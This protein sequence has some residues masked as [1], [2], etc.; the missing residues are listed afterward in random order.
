MAGEVE[1]KKKKVE[2]NLVEAYNNPVRIS[3]KAVELELEKLHNQ[4][5]VGSAEQQQVIAALSL[6]VQLAMLDALDDILQS[7]SGVPVDRESTIGI[8][9]TK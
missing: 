8:K 4:R 2:R 9:P 5:G 1:N 7:L 6:Q 3:R